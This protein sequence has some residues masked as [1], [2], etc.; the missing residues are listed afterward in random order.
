MFFRP[1]YIYDSPTFIISISLST[2]NM[3]GCVCIVLEILVHIL[4][5]DGHRLREE[6][7]QLRLL[8]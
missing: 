2:T 6:E 7:E 8:L 4:E 3:V 5:L 1:T